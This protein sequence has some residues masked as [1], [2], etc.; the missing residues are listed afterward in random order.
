[1]KSTTIEVPIQKGVP[2]EY[3]YILT[4]EAHEA[5]GIMAGDLHCRMKIKKHAVFDRK[6]ADLWVTKNITLLEALTGFNFEIMHL[7][8]TKIHIATMPGEAI[9]HGDE[10]MVRNKGMPFFEDEMGHG[11]LFIKFNVDFPKRGQL[12]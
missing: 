9:G 7:D 1:L 3:D 6:G 8:K 10:K 5:P 11:N 12:K 4:G 2:N